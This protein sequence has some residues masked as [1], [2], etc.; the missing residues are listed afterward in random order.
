MNYRQ[1]QTQTLERPVQICAEYWHDECVK[2]A[3]I[4][5]IM[6]DGKEHYDAWCD[7]NLPDAVV[8]WHVL[9]KLLDAE[10]QR[11][12]EMAQIEGQDHRD[13]MREGRPV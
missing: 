11:R 8:D 7:A 10:Y 9:Y 12:L 13:E 2:L 3:H 4:L 1:H 6:M 5:V